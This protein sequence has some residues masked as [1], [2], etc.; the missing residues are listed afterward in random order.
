MAC[1]CGRRCHPRFVAAG[2][3]DY[4]FAHKLYWLVVNAAFHPAKWPSY[5]RASRV[6]LDDHA[7][8]AKRT[9]EH[10]MRQ[11]QR[12]LD[13]TDALPDRWPEGV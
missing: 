8:I 9:L 11:Q 5:E 7:S 6:G 10:S 12:T 13:E 3:R 4:S 2:H 1:T